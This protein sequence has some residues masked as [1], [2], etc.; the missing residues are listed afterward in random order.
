M[1]KNDR[2]GK[3]NGWKVTNEP[4]I[5]LF[6]VPGLQARRKGRGSG[7]QFFRWSAEA[8]SIERA[9]EEDWPPGPRL[10]RSSKRSKHSQC[11]VSWCNALPRRARRERIELAS[12]GLVLRYRK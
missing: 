8:Y 4:A 6:I 3:S 2:R 12:L 10:F 5:L 11:R 9:G 1:I 7:G